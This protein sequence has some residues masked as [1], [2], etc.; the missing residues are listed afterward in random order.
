MKDNN[1]R[2]GYCCINLSLASRKITA[3]RGMIKRTFQAK[4]QDYCSLLAHQNIKDVLTILRWNLTHEI[5]VY[6]I[7]SDIFPWMSEYEIQKLPNFSEILKDLQKIGEFV[8]ANGIR[9]SMHPGQFDVL[10]SPNESV[11]RK[12]LKDLDQHCEIMDLMGLPLTHEFPI[13]IHVGGTYGD[14]EAAAERFCTNFEKLSDNTKKR[15]VVENDDKETQYSVVDLYNLIYKKISTPITF[16]FHHHRF[17]TSGLTEEE[18]L[19]LASTTWGNATQLT[20]YSS[21]KKT[22]EDASVIARSH[23]DYIYEQINTHNRTFDIELEC[24]MKDLALIKYRMYYANLRE[25][26]LPFDDKSILE[27]NQS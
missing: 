26:Y 10:P 21:C 11:V 24:K 5:Y 12:T 18:A 27:K 13:N 1:V 20:H 16:D 8:T 15:L 19:I 25:T 3:N 23:A 7:S 22:Y 6:R 14:K 17:N 2:L 9:I 4:G